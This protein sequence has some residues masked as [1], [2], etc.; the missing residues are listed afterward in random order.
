MTGNVRKIS[1]RYKK[2]RLHEKVNQTNDSDPL[3][4]PKPVR[5]G[6]LLCFRRE[7]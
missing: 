5:E 1:L 2:T 7:K 4:L 3:F 6:G